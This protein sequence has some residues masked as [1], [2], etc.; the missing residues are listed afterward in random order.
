M[1][2][3]QFANY[4]GPEVLQVQNVP[5]PTPDADDV[6]IEVKATTVNRLDL[7]QRNGSRP[8]EKLPFTPGLEAA[9]VVLNDNAGFHNGER[10]LTTRAPLAKGG[11][12]FDQRR[13]ARLRPRRIA[14]P[15][16]LSLRPMDA[17]DRRLLEPRRGP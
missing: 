8:V 13:V 3:V 1:K 7:F 15:V 11:G 5:D 4:G 17:G 12:G 14:G 6:L 2:A 9:G 10:V 16:C